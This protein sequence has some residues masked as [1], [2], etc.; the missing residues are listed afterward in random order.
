MHCIA[1]LAPATHGGAGASLASMSLLRKVAGW[2][3]KKGRHKIPNASIGRRIVIG[4]S[5]Q[6]F[7][8]SMGGALR[9][10]EVS[11]DGP[12]GNDKIHQGLR[13]SL[14]FVVAMDRERN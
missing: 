3:S 13:A 11:V 7:A 4:G 10:I 1:K 14:P 6:R 9:G 8:V 12:G 5:S 2:T